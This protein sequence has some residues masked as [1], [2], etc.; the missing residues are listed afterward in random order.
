ML[1]RARR[2]HPA[3]AAN[4]SLCRGRVFV[5]GRETFS[6]HVAAKLPPVPTSMTA[7]QVHLLSEIKA[8]GMR[9]MGFWVVSIAC[10]I[11][12]LLLV[13]ISWYM[14]SEVGNAAVR[15]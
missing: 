4:Q 12:Y 3:L 1:A 7:R 8:A 10:A 6:R 5:V 15:E 11:G 2:A 14:I 9:P 13:A